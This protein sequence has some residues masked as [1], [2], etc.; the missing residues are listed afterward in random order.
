MVELSK[1]GQE[2]L[3]KVQSEN[4]QLQSI[5]VQNQNIEMQVAEINEA[6]KEI[7]GKD[8]VYKEIAGLL[9]KS[10]AKKV[11]EELEETLEFLKLKKKQ[12]TEQESAIKK[13]LDEQQRKLMGM[14][15]GGK[16]AGM[17]E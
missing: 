2:L 8:E 9:V 13:S 15:Q 7:K 1:E 16:G 11:Q 12:F 6:L 17:A 5:M 3:M 10:D 14:L 4:Q